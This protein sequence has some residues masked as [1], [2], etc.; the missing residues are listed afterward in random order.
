MVILCSFLWNCHLGL[1]TKEGNS[2]RPPQ[3][4]YRTLTW[5]RKICS[6]VLILQFS[7]LCGLGQIGRHFWASVFTSIKSCSWTL[8]LVL[9]P[10]CLAF[11]QCLNSVLTS[12]FHPHSDRSSLQPKNKRSKQESSFSKHDTYMLTGHL[13]PFH[14]L[15]FSVF[16]LGFKF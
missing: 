4:S 15:C 10:L 9:K 5:H 14:N 2:I 6:Y 3:M 8:L 13:W 12:Q 1:S 11:Y 16:F 7:K